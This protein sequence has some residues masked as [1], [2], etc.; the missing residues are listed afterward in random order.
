[1]LPSEIL[2]SEGS[3]SLVGSGKSESKGRAPNRNDGTCESHSLI[4]KK[5]KWKI[6]K[7]KKEEIRKDKSTR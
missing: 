6:D 5:K 1:M 2:S 4:K 3:L 7:G